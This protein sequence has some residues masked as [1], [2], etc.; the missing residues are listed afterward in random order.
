MNAMTTFGPAWSYGYY[1]PY[2]P[3]NWWSVYGYRYYEPPVTTTAPELGIDFTN[4]SSKEIHVVEFGLVTNGNLVAEVRDVGK[5]SPGIEIRHRFGIS[6][7]VFPIQTALPLC[8]PLR[9]T[10][11]DG[12]VWTS[13]HLPKLRAKLEPGS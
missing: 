1:P 12:E 7:N 6:E 13:P 10:F 4:M 2:G 5:F 11:A 8:V 9:I 3:Y